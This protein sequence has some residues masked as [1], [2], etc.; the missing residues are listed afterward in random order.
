M[1]QHRSR[2]FFGRRKGRPGMRDLLEKTTCNAG[3]GRWM[4]VMLDGNLR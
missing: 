2:Q 4:D 3:I 1:S